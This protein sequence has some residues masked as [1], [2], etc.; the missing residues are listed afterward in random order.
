MYPVQIKVP[1]LVSQIVSFIPVSLWAL[2]LEAAAADFLEINL[3]EPARRGP[4]K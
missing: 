1:L 3:P 2:E 4:Q